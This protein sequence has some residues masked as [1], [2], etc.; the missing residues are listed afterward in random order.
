M[1]QVYLWTSLQE[2]FKY[3][4]TGNTFSNSIPVNVRVPPAAFTLSSDAVYPDPDVNFTVSWTVSTDANNY[5]IYTCAT[6]IMVINGSVQEIAHQITMTTWPLTRANGDYYF[7]IM[8]Y[9][10][11]GERLSNY[12]HVAVRILPGSF[13]L[14]SNASNP[15]TDGSFTLT[16][17]NSTGVVS[18]S[19]YVYGSYITQINGSLT[20]VTDSLTSTTFDISGL[21]S[22]MYYYIVI[23]HN[24]AGQTVSNCIVITVLRATNPAIG[25]ILSGYVTLACVVLGIGALAIITCRKT[26]LMRLS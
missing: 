6:P 2:L 1:F 22:S 19:V 18:Y 24:Q 17:T 13:T 15:D 8:A 23:A 21:N 10:N 14:S 25:T 20:N 12:I 4:G 11:A 9:N 5:T 26:R 3:N 16:W 7:A